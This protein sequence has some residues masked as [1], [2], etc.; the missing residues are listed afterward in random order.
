MLNLSIINQSRIIKSYE[1]ILIFFSYHGKEISN[2]R[3]EHLR[4]HSFF[5]GVFHSARQE[6]RHSMYIYNASYNRFAARE[7]NSLRGFFFYKDAIYVG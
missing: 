4:F 6:S 7:I 2:L 3:H 5:P 1:K